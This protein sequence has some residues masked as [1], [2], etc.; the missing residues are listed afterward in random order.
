MDDISY[1]VYHNPPL[2]IKASTFESHRLEFRC[3]LTVSANKL[4]TLYIIFK[5]ILHV[6]DISITTSINCSQI[7]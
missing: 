7:L 5:V 4:I 6:E 1:F 3:L 2:V